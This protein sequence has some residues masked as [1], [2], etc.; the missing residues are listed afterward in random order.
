MDVK[1]DWKILNEVLFQV[2]QHTPLAGSV[3]ES[4]G[5][6]SCLFLISQNNLVID[7]VV[8]NGRAFN[9]E[10]VG[11]H[12]QS[13]LKKDKYDDLAH[14]YQVDQ[15]VIVQKGVIDQYLGEAS[16]LGTNYFQQ[17]QL[18][19]TKLLSQMG[20]RR[21]EFIVSKRHFLIELFTSSLRRLLPKKFNVLVLL[22]T[23]SRLSP[24][25]HPGELKTLLM[26]FNNGDLEQFFEPDFSSL[27]ESRVRNWRQEFKAVGDYLE[28]RYI[29]PCYALF[30]YEEDF[31][32]LL[33]DP[34]IEP[35][36]TEKR[37]NLRQSSRRGLVRQKVRRVWEHV[38]QNQAQ[39][40]PK[41]PL[42]ASWFW[43]QSLTPTMFRRASRPP[44]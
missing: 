26:V 6:S 31:K 14:K 2:H 38:R 39:V 44:V 11:M 33:K 32:D 4:G 36:N 9:A 28:N 22:D 12:L 37:P 42:V 34:P 41:S 20:K 27:N 40:Y 43:M 1:H 16:M 7:G 8:S 29:L 5:V 35:V 24:S 10:D 30:M 19:R 23:R 25:T 15:T 18:L 17:L 3:D 21:G 13:N